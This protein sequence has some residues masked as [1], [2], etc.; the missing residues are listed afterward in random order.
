MPST[1]MAVPSSSTVAKPVLEHHRPPRVPGLQGRIP[2]ASPPLSP[3]HPLRPTKIDP[4]GAQSEEQ[5]T[6][7]DDE[8]KE[9]ESTEFSREKISL[10]P[11]DA[12]L[13]TLMMADGRLVLCPS[14]KIAIEVLCLELLP[15]Y[16]C[17]RERE[18]ERERERVTERGEKRERSWVRFLCST[19]L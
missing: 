16:G 4:V 9:E 17:R 7:R 5:K 18:R 19:I 3:S 14:P 2:S 15:S 1:T 12:S 6:M 11:S 8:I 13:E 10:P